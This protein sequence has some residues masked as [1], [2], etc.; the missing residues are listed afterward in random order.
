MN[1]KKNLDKNAKLR[2]VADENTTSKGKL[3]SNGKKAADKLGLK[4]NKK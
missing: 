1:T 3:N 2:F 4:V